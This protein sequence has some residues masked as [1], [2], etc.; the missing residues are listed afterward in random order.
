MSLSYLSQQSPP[1]TSYC[2]LA[3]AVEWDVLCFYLWDVLILRSIS[4]HQAGLLKH[5]PCT[6]LTRIIG[7]T[8]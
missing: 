2:S 7:V 5:L 4:T 1:P 8:E 6:T 3:S